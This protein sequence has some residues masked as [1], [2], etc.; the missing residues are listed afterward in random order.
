MTSRQ[1]FLLLNALMMCMFVGALD[2]AIMAT[3]MPRILADLGGFHLLS[4]VFTSYLL[5]STVVV[6]VVGKLSDMFGR[7]SFMLAGVFVFV[8]GSV[9]CGVAPSMPFLI[10]ARTVQG[11]GGGVIFACVFATLGDLFTPIERV[12]YVGYFTA[13]FTISALTGPT[14]GGFLTDGPGWR[15]C[16]YVNIP[17]GLAA[18]VLVWYLMPSV[19]RGGRLGDVDFLG[20]GLLGVATTVF[21][22]A[23]VWARSAFGFAAPQTLLLLAASVVLGV[24]FIAQERRHPEA[25]LPLYLFKNRLF[26]QAN[27]IVMAI[28]GGIFA[29]IQFLPTFVQTSLG[30]SATV[31]GLIATPQAVGV[32]ITSIIGGQIASRT[33]RYKRAV[34]LGST[35]VLAGTAAMLTLGVGSAPTLIAVYMAVMGLGLGLVMPLMST[36]VQNAVPQELMGVASS[37]R[38]FFMSIV[39]VFGVAAL[40]LVFTAGY[41]STFDVSAADREALTPA[42]YQQFLDPTLAL[43]V[44]RFAAVRTTL[45]ERPGGEQLLDRAVEAQREAV[46]SATHRLFVTTTVIAALLVAFAVTLRE[47]PLR[48]S[49]GS[50]PRVEAMQPAEGHPVEGHP[51]EGQRR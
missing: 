29:S 43:D 15:W 8:A 5:A 13:T 25:I 18:S 14:I 27:L 31:S 46:A 12:R 39:Q 32:L 41:T 24:A 10:A 4:W 9:A 22:L 19:R 20:A 35:M 30:T 51:A 6:S 34:V 16:F 40:G 17:V 26:V 38:Q 7:K 33:G 3:A 37:S 28:G 11:A 49:F 23:I 42:V 48:R 47:V 44:V 21:M 50:A 2:Q 45:L 36:L 1:K